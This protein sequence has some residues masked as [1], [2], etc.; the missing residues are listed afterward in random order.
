MA[1]VL[2]HLIPLLIFRIG[3]LTAYYSYATIIIHFIELLYDAS[4]RTL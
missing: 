1:D 4:S 2:F 3:H